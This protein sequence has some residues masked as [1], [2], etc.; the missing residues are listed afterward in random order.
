MV[1][2][3][4]ADEV[5]LKRAAGLSSD[6]DLVEEFL[7]CGVW[8]L[9]HGWGVG[10]MKLWLMSFKENVLVRS[11]TFVVDLCGHDAGVFVGELEAVAMKIIEKYPMKTEVAKSWDIRGSNIQLNQVFKLN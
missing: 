2:K 9:S 5:A 11:L 8:P 4:D 3:G 10:A 7:A 1:R 6:R